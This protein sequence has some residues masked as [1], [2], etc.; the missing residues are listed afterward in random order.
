MA[1]LSRTDR[2]EINLQITAGASEAGMLPSFAWKPFVSC[3]GL[4]KA[5][6]HAR[7]STSESTALF[8]KQLQ[9][10]LEAFASMLWSGMARY[11]LT[12]AGPC[13]HPA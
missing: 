5:L 2:R 8:F 3:A 7:R 12:E 9:I 1:P 11:Y 4:G 6:V 13:V 10:R